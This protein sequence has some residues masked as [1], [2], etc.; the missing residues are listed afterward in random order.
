MLAE[1]A[2][3]EELI[4]SSTRQRTRALVDIPPLAAR[5]LEGVVVVDA[6]LDQLPGRQRVP[7]RAAR[8]GWKRCRTA[9]DTLSHA[10]GKKGN[11][12]EVRQSN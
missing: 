8:R 12:E 1:L 3:A 4:T 10:E 9:M 5:T 2:A 6:Q 11:I 7:V